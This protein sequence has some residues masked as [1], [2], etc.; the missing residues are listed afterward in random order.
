MT[1]SQPHWSYEPLDRRK[2]MFP[3]RES[4]IWRHELD[5]LRWL[6][7]WLPVTAVAVLIGLAEGVLAYLHQPWRSTLLAHGVLLGA[8]A[9]GAYLFS[10]YLV[11]VLRRKEEAIIQ[12]QQELAARERRFRALIEHSA[13]GI[14]LLN[15]QGV[16]TYASPSTTRLL[17]YRAEE[18]IGRSAFDLLHPEDRATAMTRTRE[19]LQE[20]G[21]VIHAEVRLRHQDASWRWIEATVSNLLADPSVQSIVKNYRDITER[22]QSEA[23]LRQAHAELE[24][25]VEARTADLVR[26]NA[27]LEATL[28]EQ[29]LAEAALRESQALLTGIIASAL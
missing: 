9:A 16:Y 24:A 1:N 7:V 8:I 22:K 2:L 14:V 19:A 11:G 26:A 10:T 17:G 28:A 4:T 20:P 21:V 6:G 18:V 15:A 23:A 25:R 13:D 29:A 5:R 27:A 12:T 3:P